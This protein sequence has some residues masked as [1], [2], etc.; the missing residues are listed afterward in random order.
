VPKRRGV[1]FGTQKLACPSHR[2][3]HFVVETHEAAGQNSLSKFTTKATHDAV[4]TQTNGR[5]I[6]NLIANIVL[7]TVSFLSQISKL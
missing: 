7:P 3:P 6:S 5:N 1:V 4:Y 2:E